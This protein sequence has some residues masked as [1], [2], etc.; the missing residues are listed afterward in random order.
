LLALDRDGIDVALPRLGPT[1]I[2][3]RGRHQAANAAVADALLDALE[4]AG[5]ARIPAAARREG[6]ARVSWPGRLELIEVGGREVLLDGAHNPA[7]AATLAAAIDDL[8][9][10]L[11]PGRLTLVTASMADKDVT[12]IVAALGRTRALDGATVI[13]TAVDVARAMPA[14]DLAGVWR[15]AGIA[16]TVIA[17]PDSEKAFEAAL[18]EADGPIVVA[19][20]LYLVGAVRARHVV[21]PQLDD[22]TAAVAR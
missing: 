9:P 18:A 15:A 21:D 19:G 16:S 11:A 14:A 7:G 4:V 2:G 12:G 5:I 17:E 6:Y 8:R 22:A 10:Y 20:S 3:L 13:A 1:R